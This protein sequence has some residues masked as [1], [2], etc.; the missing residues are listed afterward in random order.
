MYIETVELPGNALAV[1]MYS[2]N[3]N[4]AAA[5]S[6]DT[7]HKPGSTADRRLE[8]EASVE[9]LQMYKFQ[10]KE[11]AATSTIKVPS[12]NEEQHDARLTNLFYNLENLRKRDG[13][14]RD[15]E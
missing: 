11:L 12:G 2:S 1:G 6:I 7:I 15:E 4:T 13:D 14:G 5:V 10:G 8:T 3:S 9:S